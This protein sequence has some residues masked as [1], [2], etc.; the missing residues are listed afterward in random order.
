MCDLVGYGVGLIMYEELMVFNYG[1]V[2]CGF[3]FCEGMVLIIELMIN[4]GDWEIDIDMKIGWV[5]KIIDGG[6]LC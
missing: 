2:G 4:I 5:Y 6:L 1:I 3:C